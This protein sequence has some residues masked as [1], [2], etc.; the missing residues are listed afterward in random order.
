MVHVLL[1]INKLF[2][3][4]KKNARTNDYMQQKMMV[5]ISFRG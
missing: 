5:K 2:M 3:A 4:I 1:L